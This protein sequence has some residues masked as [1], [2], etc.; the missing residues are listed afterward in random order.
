MTIIATAPTS[1]EVHA[2]LEPNGMELTILAEVTRGPFKAAIKRHDAR[3]GDEPYSDEPQIEID[4]SEQ[5]GGECF[6]D[7]TIL[8]QYVDDFAAVAMEIASDYQVVTSG[9]ETE[10]QD[11]AF[12]GEWHRSAGTVGTEGMF[13]GDEKNEVYA[14]TIWM[15]ND[16]R[17]RDELFVI[18]TVRSH[19]AFRPREAMEFAVSL[20]QEASRAI[21]IENG[22]VR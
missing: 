7:L 5:D 8:P 21:A 20:A 19:Q 4:C 17:E 16:A 22:M 2:R 9:I 1:A 15:E 12:E 11:G 18:A 14:S 10:Y 3:D 13:V 6:C